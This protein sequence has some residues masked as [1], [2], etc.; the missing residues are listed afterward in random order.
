MYDV[1]HAGVP[2]VNLAG[3]VTHLDASAASFRTDK[4]SPALFKADIEA[5]KRLWIINAGCQL[6]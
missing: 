4:N 2:G 1:W 6:F 5:F 3:P